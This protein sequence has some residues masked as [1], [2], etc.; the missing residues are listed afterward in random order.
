MKRSVD[1]TECDLRGKVVEGMY[2]EGV[3]TSILFTDNT[4]ILLKGVPRGGITIVDENELEIYYNKEELNV[5]V[6]LGILSVEEYADILD[7]IIGGRGE[8]K[9]R[10][11]ERLT[12]E[13]EKL[14]EELEKLI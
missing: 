9:K 8:P 3:Y 6:Q 1:L 2:T 12:K 10:R 13:I 4:Y 11:V 14:Q 7:D 5:A